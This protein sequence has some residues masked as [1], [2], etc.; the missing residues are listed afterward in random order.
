M[1]VPPSSWMIAAVSS[2]V[3]GRPYGEGWPRALRP[4]QYTSAPASP[5]AR[6]MPRPAPRVAPATTATCPVSGFVMRRD[7]RSAPALEGASEKLLV[8]TDT[9]HLGGV[10]ERHAELESAVDG[11]NRLRVVAFA[12][13]LAHPHATEA[14]LRNLESL[15]SELPLLEHDASFFPTPLDRLRPHSAG[16]GLE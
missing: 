3:S 6:A 15:L 13:G 11:R 9:V 2:I 12:V 4:V 7:S 16:A 10:E 1:A 14:Q 8:V 5:R